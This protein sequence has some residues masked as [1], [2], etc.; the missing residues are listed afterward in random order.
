MQKDAWPF[1]LPYFSIC[2]NSCFLDPASYGLSAWKEWA[3]ISLLAELLEQG[4]NTLQTAVECPGVQL[5]MRLVSPTP[6]AIDL[7]MSTKAGVTGSDVRPAVA[8]RTGEV[9]SNTS[10]VFHGSV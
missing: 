1:A 7:Q 2:N 10:S 8:L 9:I 3:A 5:F 4:M 6:A